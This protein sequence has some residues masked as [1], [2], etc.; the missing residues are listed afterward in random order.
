MNKQAIIFAVVAASLTSTAAFAQSDYR[1]RG[2]R[3][4]R[5][6]NRYDRGDNRYERGD[7]RYDRNDRHDRAENR[8]E[9]RADRRD[10]RRDYGNRYDHNRGYSDGRYVVGGAG[11]GRNFYRGGYLSHEYRDNRYVVSDWQRYRLSAPPRGHHWVRAGDD[12]V[13]AVIAT[14]LIANILINN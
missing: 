5:S 6:D 7:N 14:G 12:Y 4:E 8:W 2:E 13:L 1:E 11:P 3:S 10:D 9:R